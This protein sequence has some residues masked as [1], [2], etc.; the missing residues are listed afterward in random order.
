MGLIQTSTKRPQP[1]NND[2]ALSLAKRRRSIDLLEERDNRRAQRLFFEIYPEEDRV[3][4]GPS[5]MGGLI[6]PRQTL[7]SRFNIA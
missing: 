7:Y 2:G 3:E 6:E 4:D 1:H 5:L